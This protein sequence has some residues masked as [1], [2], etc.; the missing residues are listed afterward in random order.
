MVR[1]LFPTYVS[2]RKGLHKRTGTK[3]QEAFIG[4]IFG[5]IIRYFF[6][7]FLKNPLF[8]HSDARGREGEWPNTERNAPDK[9]AGFAYLLSHIIHC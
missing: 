7:V 1:S 5:I 3:L 4:A 8:F 6:F 2:P 9:Y